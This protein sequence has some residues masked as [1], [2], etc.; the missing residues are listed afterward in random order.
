MAQAALAIDRQAPVKVKLTGDLDEDILRVAAIRAARPRA[1]I[2]VDATQGYD[3][4]TLAALLTLLVEHGVA[5]FEQQPP[6]GAEDRKGVLVGKSVSVRGDT[7]G[8]RK[9]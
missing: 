1:S 3:R 4:R 7:G 8:G 5:H 2:G 9:I 6:P